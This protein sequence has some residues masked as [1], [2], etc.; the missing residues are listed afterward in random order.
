MCGNRHVQKKKR[1]GGKKGGENKEKK[2]QFL[3]LFRGVFHST[4]ALPCFRVLIESSHPG[5]GLPS[6]S[7]SNH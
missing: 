2:G 4:M 5:A 7:R 6:S 3:G 1:D